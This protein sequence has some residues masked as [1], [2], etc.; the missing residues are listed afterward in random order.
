[1]AA[2]QWIF[3]AS[4]RDCPVGERTRAMLT[5]LAR[6]GRNR[7][8]GQANPCTHDHA[9]AMLTVATDPRDRAIVA[10]LFMAG[11]RRSEVAALLWGDVRE[12]EAGTLLVR[13]RAA[14]TDPEGTRTYIRLVKS[15]FAAALR[16]LRPAQAGP[17]DRVIGLTGQRIAQRF[18][19]LAARA[20]VPYRLTGHSGRVGLASELI[21]RGASTAEVMLAGAWKS[22]HMV[23]HYGAASRTARGA[24]AKYL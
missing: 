14:K 16:A 7:G 10:L 9:V 2:F 5:I 3:K 21:A 13:V 1:V 19:A 8:R 23:A 24:V 17:D 22:A 4:G 20:G 6:E 12:G 15:G 18:T 11:M